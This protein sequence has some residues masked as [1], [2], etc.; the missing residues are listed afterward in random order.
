MRKLLALYVVTCAL[1][2]GAMQCFAQMTMMGVNIGGAAGGGGGGI[3]FAATDAQNALS[4]PGTFTIA[5]GTASTDRI[6]LA[7]FEHNN[8]TGST[9]TLNGS[10]M[11]LAAGTG[12]TT[13]NITLYY[14]NITTGTTAAFA[15]AAGPSGV[16]VAVGTLKGQS[17]GGGAASTNPVTYTA[18]GV[19]PLSVSLT[20]PAGGIGIACG[21][22]AFGPAGTFTWT[23]TTSGAG[24]E[25]TGNANNETGSAHSTSTGTV[26]V[27]SSSSLSFGGTMAAASWAP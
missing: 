27:L 23:G 26:T 2:F 22:G 24:D 14:A 4:T 9:P 11:T 6:V 7:C 8:P 16:G 19:Q 17:G 25:T 15:Y 12:A 20:V 1:L 5:I 3:T 18:G 21:G 10:G 13:T